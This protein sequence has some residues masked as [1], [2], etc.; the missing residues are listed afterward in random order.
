MPGAFLFKILLRAQPVI[1]FVARRA[2]AS[3]EYLMSALAN[4]LDGRW[5]A[6]SQFGS[7]LSGVTLLFS[8]FHGVY[9]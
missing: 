7:F 8:C 3:H 4:F 1:Q 6:R 2:A 9:V 5:N